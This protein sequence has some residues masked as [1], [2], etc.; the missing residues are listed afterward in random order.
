MKRQPRALTEKYR[1]LRR[2]SD[3]LYSSRLFQTFFNKFIKKGKKVL[4]QRT[5]FRAFFLF[6][7]NVRR[8]R[9][10]N[11]LLQ[12]VQ[13]L[14]SQ[15]LLLPRR[16][17]KKILSIP[18]PIRRNKRDLISIHALYRAIILRKDRVFFRNIS[19]E[20]ISLTLDQ[21]SSL[22]LRDLSSQKQRVF[23]ERVNMD[24]R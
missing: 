8:P 10:S 16:K 17:G 6:R 13:T 21:T 12:L 11:C 5:L 1:T 3:S 2:N 15:L 24:L 22:T 23:E 20:L 4:A 18:V 9:V 19:D 7:C 14:R